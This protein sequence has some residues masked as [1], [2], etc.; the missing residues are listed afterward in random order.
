MKLRKT[1]VWYGTFI[2][3]LV[4]NQTKSFADDI[5]VKIVV[6]GLWIALVAMTW[7]FFKESEWD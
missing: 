7:M 6:H 1:L 5:V 3:A 2:V 4:L